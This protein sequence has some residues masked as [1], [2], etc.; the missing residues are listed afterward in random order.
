MRYL[1]GW[2]KKN[3][4]ALPSVA[5]TSVSFAKSL[6]AKNNYDKSAKYIS[7]YNVL[8]MFPEVKSF[9]FLNR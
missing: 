1:D 9:F 4:Q 7:K 8:D 2:T 6:E 5:K 3:S